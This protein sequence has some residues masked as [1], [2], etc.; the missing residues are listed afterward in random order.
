MSP[1]VYKTK[2]HNKLA[3]KNEGFFL[4]KGNQDGSWSCH[5]NY[6]GQRNPSSA[7]TPDFCY[8]SAV[9]ALYEWFDTLDKAFTASME[10]LKTAPEVQNGFRAG[11]KRRAMLEKQQAL[12][13]TAAS[14]VSVKDQLKKTMQDAGW[15]TPELQ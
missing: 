10:D 3:G 8:E 1:F 14:V 2:I 15:P 6:D 11:W 13:R 7:D 4:V 12:R 9:R 5:L